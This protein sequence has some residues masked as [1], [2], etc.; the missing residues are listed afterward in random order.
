MRKNKKSSR[1]S[2]VIRFLASALLFTV[3]ASVLGAITSGSDKNAVVVVSSVSE[4]TPVIAVDPGHGGE[5][6]GASGVGGIKEKDLNLKI[7]K[8]FVPFLSAG[9]YEV[10]LTRT[11][12][13]M[14]YDLYDDQDDYSGK[15]KTLDLKNR[16]RFAKECDADLLVSVHMNKFFMPQYGGLQVYY[17]PNVPESE[18]VASYVQNCVR[19]SLC[20]ENDRQIKRA[21]SSIYLL[22]NIQRGAILIE[23][24][25]LSNENDLKN[26]TNER[27]ELDLAAT[28]CSSIIN[29]FASDE[30]PAS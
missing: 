6:P 14:L 23:C 15:K 2:Y 26:L 24:G 16:I 7:A 1:Q 8:L 18:A 11:D 3:T 19:E 9:G 21:T 27:Y 13:R 20:P 5:D 17:S 29:S 25:F 10:R 30:K 12:D 28:I 4:K 22:S